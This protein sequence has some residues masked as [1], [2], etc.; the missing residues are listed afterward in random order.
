MVKPDSASRRTPAAHTSSR[1]R[2]CNSTHL[3]FPSTA[4]SRHRRIETSSD[5]RAHA[6]TR[7]AQ[8]QQRRFAPGSR[9]AGEPASDFAVGK[10]VVPGWHIECSARSLDLLGEGFRHRRRRRRPD[11]PHHENERAR[12]QARAIPSRGYWVKTQVMVGAEKN[13]QVARKLHDAEGRRRRRTAGARCAW[14][15]SRP[16]TAARSRSV[17]ASSTDA[18]RSRRPGRR[19]RPPGASRG[20]APRRAS[21]RTLLPSATAAMDDDFGTRKRWRWCSASAR[22]T[23]QR[24]RRCRPGRAAAGAGHG[25]GVGRALG[26]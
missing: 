24:G 6:S 7:R 1:G 8:A 20:V 18:A 26:L 13:G 12:A 16:A 3:R 5:R 10:R 17:T 11:L 9:Q 25:A 2:A 21:T 22:D 4:S 14:R 15:D 23:Q 19:A